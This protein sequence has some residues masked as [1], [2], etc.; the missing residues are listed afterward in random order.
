MRLAIFLRKV[1]ANFHQTLAASSNS[2][3][4]PLIT[5]I[6]PVYSISCGVMSIATLSD[7]SRNECS[8]SVSGSVAWSA[9]WKVRAMS[10]W[11]RS[12]T[13]GRMCWKN[14]S[15][16]VGRLRSL[17]FKLTMLSPFVM[18]SPK[19]LATRKKDAQRPVDNLL[20]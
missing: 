9:C 11:C 7:S 2:S 6:N 8:I 3:P 1:R 16:S 20:D 17:H 5:C 10:Y 15:R 4:C 12:S 19:D 18:P 14:F 13:C